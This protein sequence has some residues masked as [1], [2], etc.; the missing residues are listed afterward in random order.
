ME[1]WARANPGLQTGNPDGV[2]FLGE[3]VQGSKSQ[4]QSPRRVGRVGRVGVG[5]E[6]RF[7]ANLA[8][9]TYRMDLRKVEEDL[10]GSTCQH[11]FQSLHSPSQ[12]YLRPDINQRFDS[13]SQWIKIPPW[14]TPT[15]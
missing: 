15:D 13:I 2:L 10:P 12:S 7:W 3:E 14:V 9:L 8:D 6:P 1:D 4:V 11:I 5:R